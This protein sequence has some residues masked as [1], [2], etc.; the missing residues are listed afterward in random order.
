MRK[1]VKRVIDAASADADVF[2]QLRE[3]PDALSE[4]L[5]LSRHDVAALRAS[6]LLL[7]GQ[8]KNPLVQVTTYTIS[9]GTTCWGTGITLTFDDQP[10]SLADL[11]RER[12]LEVTEQAL[13]DAEYRRRLTEF[14][15]P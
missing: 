10:Q 6:D 3:D 1:N 7:V 11:D 14:L 13:Q 8:P 15:Y 9:S 2:E 4:R 12:L 5:D